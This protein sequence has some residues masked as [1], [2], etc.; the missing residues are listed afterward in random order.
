MTTVEVHQPENQDAAESST[1]SMDLE[2]NGQ[3]RDNPE[4][5]ENTIVI[6]VMGGTGAGKSTF[7][8]L[9]TDQ[10][11]QV[12]HDLKSCTTE[13]GAYS[14]R[15]NDQQIVYVVDTPGFDDT[16]RPDSEILQEIAFFL[17]AIY[18]KKVR[19]AGLIY[20]H[21]ITDTRVSG[22]SLKNMQVFQRL[23]GERAF[24]SVIL[25][26]T[27]WAALEAIEDGGEIG[28]QRCNQLRRPEFWGEMLQ[29]ES[30]MMEHDG[31]VGSARS[32]VS[33]LV[34]KKYS[35]VLDIQVQMVNE[36]R[37]LDETE[38][39]RYLQKDFLEARKRYEEDLAEFQES[40]EQALAEKDTETM[41]LIKKE[42]EAAESRMAK[43]Q[44]N[45]AKLKVSLGQLATRVTTE[46]HSRVSNFEPSPAAIS[47]SAF[48]PRKRYEKDLAEFQESMEQTVA[49]KDA[50]IVD[51]IKKER[52]AA[53]SRMAKLQNDN[54]Q[55]KVSL[56]QLATRV[57]AEYRSRVS[58]FEPS[59]ATIS[60]SAFEP[61]MEALEKELVQVKNEL[62]ECQRAYIHD[63]RQQRMI[64]E[65]QAAANAQ[66]ERM[67][68]Q[69]RENDFINKQRDIEECM[70]SQARQLASIN[71]DIEE[72]YARER[73]RNKHRSWMSARGFIKYLMGAF[74]DGEDE[75]DHSTHR[76]HSHRTPSRR[77]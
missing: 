61:R 39:G 22:S 73:K 3:P 20:L 72:W 18:V 70:K 55:L 66:Q 38:A 31:S 54:A 8:S 11:V 48:E 2:L 50:E 34:E 23:C 74:N 45:N 33:K 25:V 29:R 62:Q 69:E 32:I 4:L 26:T 51:L 57:M 40:M 21:R 46:Y 77:N 67:K 13:V 10:A 27:M 65:H 35:A 41:D 63:I 17:S 71:S 49:E 56:D 30:I 12:G 1:R 36:N 14:F 60:D 58:N 42:R 16:S 76:R 43:L 52:E 68:A 64:S 5:S 75:N 19:L 15:Y 37:S 7:I 44:N 28:R 6:V 59:P 24:P 9:L 53:K 47:D